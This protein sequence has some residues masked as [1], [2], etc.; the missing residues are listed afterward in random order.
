[1]EWEQQ[2]L[3]ITTSTVVQNYCTHNSNLGEGTSSSEV[4]ECRIEEEDTGARSELY[5]SA[6]TSAM[7]APRTLRHSRLFPASL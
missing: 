2:I 4:K 6:R 7:I 1:M 5:R 3:Y